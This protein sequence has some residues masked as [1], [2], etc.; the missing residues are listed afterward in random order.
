MGR[1]YPQDF[2]NNTVA[3]TLTKTLSAVTIA[4]VSYALPIAAQASDWYFA[5][6]TPDNSSRYFID[7]QSI[8]RNNSTARANYLIVY[9]NSDDDVIGLTGIDEYDCVQNKIKSVETVLLYENGSS[10]KLSKRDEW[11]YFAPGTVGN[12]LIK[13]VCGY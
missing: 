6:A 8:V 13:Q 12:S 7:R 11:N 5:T 2:M 9:S 4:A 1:L 10:K 3:R